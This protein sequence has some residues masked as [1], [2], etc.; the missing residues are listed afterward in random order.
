MKKL[1]FVCAAFLLTAGVTF[2]QT[3]DQTPTNQP[4]KMEKSGKMKDCVMMKDGKMWMM[5]DGQKT[6]M[7]QNMTMTNGST[8]MADGTVKNKDGKTWMMKDGESMDMSGKMKKKMG[9]M[10]KQM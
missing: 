7:T 8:V 4:S 5:K 3:P 6:E 9:K 2:A 1:F 10:D